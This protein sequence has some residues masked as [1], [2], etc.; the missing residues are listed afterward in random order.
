VGIDRH[1]RDTWPHTD[2]GQE[3]A[4]GREITLTLAWDDVLPPNVDP[5]H[6]TASGT[7]DVRLEPVNAQLR[8]TRSVLVDTAALLQFEE[9]LARLLDDLT[10]TVTLETL[11]DYR[12][13]GKWAITVT[14]KYGKAPCR[15]F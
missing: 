3:I 4:I 1:F 13:K 12:G 7:L 10:G 9:A 11:V 8:G 5:G 6:R 15:G 2:L 14:L